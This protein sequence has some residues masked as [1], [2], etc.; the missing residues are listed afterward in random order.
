MRSL[1]LETALTEFVD[2]AAQHLRKEIAAGAEVPF[3]LG[4]QRGRG[5]RGGGTAAT[6]LYCYTALTGAFIAEREADLQRLTA[7]GHA[8]GLLEDFDGLDRYLTGAGVEVGRMR[9]SMRAN[10]ALRALLQDVFEEQTDF[11]VRPERLAAALE[12]LEQSTSA[13]AGETMLVATLHGVAISSPELQLTRGLTIARPEALR[14]AP[15][16]AIAAGEDGSQDHLLVVLGLDDPDRAQAAPQDALARG[17]GV[18]KDLLRALR[19]F[20]DGRVTLGALAWTQVTGTAERWSPVALGTGGRPHGML[21]VTAEQADELRAFCNLVSR[22]APH[23][24]EL[25]WAL[26]R[27]ELGCERESWHE[28]L[29]DHLMALRALLEPEGPGSGL[30][31]GRLAALCATPE[32]RV[33]LTERIVRALAL[34]RSVIAGAPVPRAADET[35]A[36]DVIANH[37]R[38]LLR[39][40]ICGHLDPDLAALADELL[41]GDEPSG[42][43]VASDPG[44]SREVLDVLV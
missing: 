28:A 29:S 1:Q 9:G 37:L 35:L 11:D 27:F 31:A 17:R 32:H 14:G 3:E 24:N 16:G 23:G 8:A 44:E 42:E 25:A 34:E 39:D 7:H 10:A 19:L 30:L 40:V 21:V 43:E 6:Q 15:E 4:S 20:G 5:A 36:T 38:A 2:A 22:R 18:L 41:L 26:R 13:S 33:G 12:R